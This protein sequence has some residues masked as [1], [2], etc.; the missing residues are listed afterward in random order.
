MTVTFV[1][2]TA[3]FV[4]YLRAQIP[5]M[6]LLFVLMFSAICL[7]LVGPQLV[8]YFLDTAISGGPLQTLIQVAL[9]FLAL[10]LVQ[11]ILVVASTYVAEDTAWRATNDLRADLTMHCL[12]LDMS[13]HHAHSPGEMIERIDGDVTTLTN[14]FSRFVVQVLGNAVLLVGILLLL[15]RENWQTGMVMT[16]FTIVS[17]GIIYS[18]RGKASPFFVISQRARA[19]LASFWEEQ[20]SGTRDVRSNGAVPYVTRRHLELLWQE[21][22]TLRTAWLQGSFVA[23]APVALFGIVTT[24]ALT[25]GFYLFERQVI[26]IGTVYLFF[27]YSQLLAIPLQQLATQVEDLQR[28][29]AGLIRSYELRNTA[30]KIK[31]GPGAA[32]LSAS[33]GIEFSRVTFSYGGSSTV[34]RDVSF[35]I[36]PGKVLGILGRTG[37]GKS[38]IARLLCRLYDPSG[39]TVYVNGIDIRQFR[40]SDLRRHIGIVTQE[41]QLFG[42]TLRANLTLFDSSISDA[43]ILQVL[44][45][46]G[47]SEW[48]LTLPNGLDTELRSGSL[49][50]GGEAQLVAFARILLNDP[51]IVILDEATSRLDPKSAALVRQATDHLLRGRTGIIIAHQLSTVEHVDEILVLDD[52]QVW[53]HGPAGVLS[54]NPD[55]HYSRLL[56]VVAEDM[57]S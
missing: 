39:G 51:G 21:M 28:A 57:H 7:Q 10:A 46:V 30:T 43:H 1:Q 32:V 47:L 4:R 50:S 24:V 56:K 3:M 48:F 5:N 41:V 14:F 26:S 33:L 22:H 16:L 35:S 23:Q 11:Q 18:L 29:E 6:L 53:E 15:Y 17:V 12:Q 52:G 8:R 9:L 38:S 25:L 27:S 40:L 54:S 2:Y 55:S 45:K 49:L 19:N 36:Q 42:A 44:E 37:A 20:F 13:F 34:L 31:D